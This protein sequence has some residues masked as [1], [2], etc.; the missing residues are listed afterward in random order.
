MQPSNDNNAA[1]V[2]GWSL[3]RQGVPARLATVAAAVAVLWLVVLWA[4]R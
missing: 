1:R 3:F 4:L 2:R